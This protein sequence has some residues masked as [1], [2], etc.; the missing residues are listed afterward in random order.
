MYRPQFAYP[1]PP[2]CRDE[3]F[4]YYFDG[5][6]VPLLANGITAGGLIEYIPL[7]LEQDAPF[8]LRGWKVAIR[9]KLTSGCP[10][11]TVWSYRLPDLGVRLRDCYQNDLMDNYVP[12]TQGAF[13]ENPVSFYGSMLT[14]P[15][16]PLESE[17][18]CPRG[19]V[20]QVFLLGG[21]SLTGTSYPLIALFGVKRYKECA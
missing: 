15:P 1:T 17:V 8:Y 16:T 11:S 2:G 14:G 4:V 10:P 5:S 20:L 12:A 19:G 9:N 18:Y 3:D 13:P 21:S 7:T 6:N